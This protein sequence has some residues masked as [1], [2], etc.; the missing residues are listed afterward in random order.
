[1]LGWKH[2]TLAILHAARV[3]QHES[4]AISFFIL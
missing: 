4:G 2:L 1:M 3:R